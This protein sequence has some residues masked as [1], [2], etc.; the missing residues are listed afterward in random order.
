MTAF[1]SSTSHICARN[2]LRT[3]PTCTL[4]KHARGGEMEEEKERLTQD[5]T[6]DRGASLA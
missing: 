3:E 4:D 1:C 6:I 2:A 5:R